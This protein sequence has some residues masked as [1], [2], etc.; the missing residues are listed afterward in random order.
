MGQEHQTAFD[1]IKSRLQKPSV[2]HL[3]NNKGRFHLYS[4]TSKYAMGSALY[5]MQNGKPKLMAYASKRL[6]EAAKNYS[7]TEL[8]MSG[9]AIN[10]TS[11][12]HLLK[13]V[14]FDAIVDHLALVH[15]LK[16]KTELAT[17]RIKRLL[18]VLSA[19]SFNF[20]Y[21]IGKNMMLSDFLVRQMTD[22]SNPHE[23]MPISFNMKAILKD[24]YY[25]IV[26]DSRYLAQTHSQAKDSGI[27]LPEV[28]SVDKGINPYIKPERRILKSQNPVNKPKLGQA[29]E[30]LRREMKAPTQVQLQSQD[31]NQTRE[32]TISKQ[33][34][35]IQTPLTKQIT[36]RH[37]EQ[38]PETSIIPEHIIRLKVTGIQ[39]PIYPD[40]LMKLPPRLPDIKMQ[41]DRKI[42]LDLDLE[43]NKDFKEN[44]PYQ[45]GIISE[46]YQR[47]HK[48]QLLEPL[49]LAD[50]IDTNNIVKK[51][52]PK[53]TDIDKILKIIQRKV[54]K[55]TYLPVT[56]KKI[57]VGYLNS[58]YF[59]DIY[60]YLTQNKLLSSKNAI[61]KVEVL[62]ER[63]IILDSLLFKLVT[64]PE[65]ETA[66]LAIPEM[67]ADKIITLYHSSLFAGHQGIIKTYLMIVD[68]FFIP[69][70]M[71]YLHSYIKECHICQFSR[72]DKLP[73][74]Q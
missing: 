35:G 32:Q 49:E 65:K 17:T 11:F 47:P 45:E 67:C 9:L 60:L 53:Q 15:I 66:L 41:D 44:S 39:I 57:Q 4:D 16:S 43:I 30:G 54:L 48:S 2:L 58:P 10:I 27:K 70:L 12:A 6:P 59:K 8:K 46:I 33:R 5:Q 19:Y 7:M 13:K 72:K 42:N 26:N 71:H 34:G 28:H 22:N 73:T 56:I 69:D 1:E 20:F 64:I 21:M 14:D 51:Y 23:I 36:V 38:K 37:I 55:G 31:E 3:P 61:H 25:N 62:A 50:F 52:L 63:Y 68:K 24:R 40:P 74:R 18:E 29:R